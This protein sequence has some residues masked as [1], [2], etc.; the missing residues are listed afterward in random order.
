M[1]ERF[2]VD[3]NILIYS[4]D[5][6]NR[7]KHERAAQLMALALKSDC[8]L[9]LQSLAEFYHATTRKALLGRA[10][11]ASLI[12]TWIELFPTAG[13]GDGAFKRALEWAAKRRSGLWDVLLIETAKDAGCRYILSEDMQDGMDFGGLTVRDPFQGKA[14]PQDIVESLGLE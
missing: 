6:S 10:E 8:V 13:Y 4:I 2:T 9:L 11:A 3:T 14:I 1:S 5:T 7:S 12:G